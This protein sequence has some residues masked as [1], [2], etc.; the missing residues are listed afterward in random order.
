MLAFVNH[1]HTDQ[2]GQRFGPVLSGVGRM[3]EEIVMPRVYR[4]VPFLAISAST[5][6]SLERDRGGPRSGSAS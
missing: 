2:W 3:A 5:A 6:R 4:R 1:V